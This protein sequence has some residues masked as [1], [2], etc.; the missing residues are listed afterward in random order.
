MFCLISVPRLTSR[1]NKENTFDCDHLWWTLDRLQAG[2]FYFHVLQQNNVY[3]V[4][5]CMSQYETQGEIALV[6]STSIS[7]LHRAQRQDQLRDNNMALGASEKHL[8]A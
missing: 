7:P 3:N 6:S 1:E 5:T 8:H 4:C 2:C